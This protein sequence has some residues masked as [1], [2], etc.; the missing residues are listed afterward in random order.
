VRISYPDPHGPARSRLHY[1]FITEHFDAAAARTGNSRPERG[2]FDPEKL[3]AQAAARL[4]LFQFMIGNTDWSIARERNTMLLESADGRQFPVPYDLDMSGLVAA[5][6]AGPAPGLPIDDVRDRY[7]LGYCQPGTDWE[8][9]FAEFAASRASI[10]DLDDRLPGLS[11]SSQRWVHRFLEG[12][13]AIL[14]SP[15]Q[16]RRQI[17]DACQPWPPSAVDH[18]APPSSR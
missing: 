14:D 5:D 12:F 17:T 10:L 2:H 3:D 16:R 4:A 1:A 11:R 8:A 6:Y 18:L 13:F 7:F 15:E 9:L